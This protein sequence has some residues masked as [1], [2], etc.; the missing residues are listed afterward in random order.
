[1]RLPA[2]YYVTSTVNPTATLTT[3][4]LLKCSVQAT[5]QELAAFNVTQYSFR[6]S[7]DGSCKIYVSFDYIGNANGLSLMINALKPTSSLRIFNRI[8]ASRDES[9]VWF[10]KMPDNVAYDVRCDEQYTEGL[11]KCVQSLPRMG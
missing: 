3:L 2:G 1:M 10:L 6:E 11:A 9:L 4:S 5:I 8:L 7:D